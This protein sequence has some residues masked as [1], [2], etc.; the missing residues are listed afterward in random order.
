MPYAFFIDD[1]EITEKLE[2]CLK[3]KKFTNELV[4]DIIYQEQ[5]VFKVR[6]ITRCTR[7]VQVVYL[8]T[9]NLFP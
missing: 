3:D 1:K 2:D 9:C 5:A 6:P 7:L 8:I 4:I